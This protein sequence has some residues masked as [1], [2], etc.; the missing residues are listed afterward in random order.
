VL[1]VTGLIK[2]QPDAPLSVKVASPSNATV[3]Q[4]IQQ[5]TLAHVGVAQPAEMSFDMQRAYSLEQG[6]MSVGASYEWL[7]GGVKASLDTKRIETHTSYI[8]RFVQRYYTVS[9]ND[10]TRQSSFIDVGNTDEKQLPRW[11]F[12]GSKENG[13]VDSPP[14]YVSNVSYGRMLYIMISSDAS[15]TALSSALRASFS[16]AVASGKLALD[17]AQSSILANS[18]VQVLAVGG[19]GPAAAT[20]ITGVGAVEKLNEY[21]VA[22][23]TF[24]PKKDPGAPISYQLR[25]LVDNTVARLSFTTDYT[26]RTDRPNP[27][28][29]LSVRRIFYVED[30]DKDTD[31]AITEQVLQDGLLLAS[32]THSEHVRYYENSEYGGSWDA[33]SKPVSMNDCGRMTY[34]LSVANNDGWRLHMVIMGRADDGYDYQMLSTVKFQ[35]ANDQPRSIDFPLSC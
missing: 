1:T 4:A 19:G 2:D 16:G 25:Y 14:T 3:Q 30:D 34:R 18:E 29:I 8:V 21:I 35:M 20:V 27:A 26:I 17:Q 13:N 22:G 6:L 5:L 10:P 12:P 31:D 28:N 9:V 7:T 23:A 11:I 33:L 15:E 32:H 24:D